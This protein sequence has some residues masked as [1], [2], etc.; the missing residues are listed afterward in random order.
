MTREVTIIIR[1]ANPRLPAITGLP[2]W[3]AREIAAG[4]T[5]PELTIITSTD[6]WTERYYSHGVNIPTSRGR[7]LARTLNIYS[8]VEA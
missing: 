8:N 3:A 6:G 1:T 2:F 5:T 4:L 7:E